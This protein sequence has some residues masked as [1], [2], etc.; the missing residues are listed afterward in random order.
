MTEVEI[1]LRTLLLCERDVEVA[2]GEE[3]RIGV[4]QV[5]KVVSYFRLGHTLE[6]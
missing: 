6:S 3:T 5:P 2:L 1:V 4:V